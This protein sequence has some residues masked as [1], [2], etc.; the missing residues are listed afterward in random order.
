MR[1]DNLC[2][3]VV[4]WV[5]SLCSLR[6]NPLCWGLRCS[7]KILSRVGVPS[8]EST[9]CLWLWTGGMPLDRFLR[10]EGSFQGSF[11]SC[12]MTSAQEVVLKDFIWNEISACSRLSSQF[13]EKGCAYDCAHELERI[14]WG[15]GRKYVV[16]MKDG[17]NS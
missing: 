9:T 11:E 1:W 12:T 17:L 5:Y 14:S 6:L 2:Q 4:C 16:K 10:L 15:R 3:H 13:V 7:V 8:V